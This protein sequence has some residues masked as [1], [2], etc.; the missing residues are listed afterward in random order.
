M[1]IPPPTTHASYKNPSSH[2]HRKLV[3][4]TLAAISALCPCT[5]ATADPIS[6]E[7]LLKTQTHKVDKTY[8]QLVGLVVGYDGCNGYPGTTY[9]DINA[10][11]TQNS[12]ELSGFGIILKGSSG[13]ESHSSLTL[14]SDFTFTQ[15]QRHS[16]SNENGFFVFN[17]LSGSSDFSL[18]AEKHNVTIVN[19]TEDGKDYSAIYMP[20]SGTF[21]PKAVQAADYTATSKNYTA[22]GFSY[23]IN[24]GHEKGHVSISAEENIVFQ[25]I[26]DFGINANVMAATSENFSAISLTAGN[27]IKVTGRSSPVVG[28]YGVRINRSTAQVNLNSKIIEISNF[29]TAVGNESAVFSNSDPDLFKDRYNGAVARLQADEIYLSDVAKGIYVYNAAGVTA[30]GRTAETVAGLIDI[31]ASEYGIY[32][33]GTANDLDFSKVDLLA[34]KISITSKEAIYTRG[35]KAQTSLRGAMT[36][37]GDITAKSSASATLVYEGLDNELTG[38]IDSSSFASVSVDSERSYALTMTGDVTTQG[39]GTVFLNVGHGSITGTITDSELQ[40]RANATGTTLRLDDNGVWN[41]TGNSFVSELITAES[42]IM[43]LHSESDTSR[44][45]PFDSDF[46]YI[47]KLSTSNDP[48]TVFMNLNH[49][50]HSSSDMLYIAEGDGAVRVLLENPLDDA[51][52][53]KIQ[54]GENL[55]FATVGKDATLT[56]SAAAVLDGG[57]N[58]LEYTVAREDY[59]VADEENADYN[60]GDKPG[61]AINDRFEEGSNWVITA[62]NSTGPSD[63]GQAVLN[64]SRA[65]YANALHQ[66][67]TL[68]Q[69]RGEARYQ[70]DADQ[71]LWLRTRHDRTGLAG[72]FRSRQTMIEVGYDKLKMTNSGQHRFGLALDYMD[73]RADYNGLQGS[74]D[75]DRWGIWAYDT[76]T[77][78]DGQYA[79]FVFK[80]GHLKNDFD[81]TSHATG[82]RVS[83]GYSNDVFSISGEFGHKFSNAEQWFVEPQV[84]MQYAYV[85]DADYRTN[86]GTEVNVDSISSLIARAGIRLGKDKIADSNCAFWIKA[87]LL[88]EFL[89]KQEIEASDKTGTLHEEFQNAGTWYDVGFGISGK[90]GRSSYLHLDAGK[91]FGNSLVSS[92]QI[93]GGVSWVF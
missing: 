17:T 63:G 16:S 28:S 20:G 15:T 52:L 55:R 14:N 77:A 70:D 6:I 54:N 89:G 53:E 4:C 34:D 62:Q 81:I 35:R 87:D 71:G 21:P 60:G 61:D 7:D 59:D 29:E 85:T 27:R 43:R 13:H 5:K 83:G 73:G 80:W 68:R 90:I 65:N 86:Q 36:I 40:T 38:N 37:N 48:L 78:D 91:E 93:S 8:G 26:K 49:E 64:M 79:D 18:L 58:N 66:L 67:D 76:W 92:Y 75:M 46:V 88:H 30:G 12:T 39:Y 56:F 11:L 44:A 45:T 32:V 33:E 47:G 69:R 84:Q 42:N 3:I 9:G 72:A 22:D 74:G 2:Q 10:E 1:L 19:S 41:V 25:N 82:T 24:V 51:T 57:V 50:D 23:G 31:K